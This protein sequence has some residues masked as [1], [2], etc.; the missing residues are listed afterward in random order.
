M[1]KVNP[2]RRSLLR[3]FMASSVGTGLSR[4]LGLARELA[5]ANVLG[6][7]MVMDAFVMAFTFPGMLRR[8]VADEGLTGALVP[9]I[10][11]AETEDGTEAARQLA[12]RVLMA[13]IAVGVLLSTAGILAAPWIVDWVADGFKGEKYTL[14]VQL[15]QVLFPFVIFVSLV[16]WAEGLLN[17]KDHF[18][19][20]KIAP[21]L[22]SA[23][24]VAAVLLYRNQG[25]IDVVWAVSWAVIIGGAIHLLICIPP[26]IKHWGAIRP[27]FDLSVDPRF[28]RVVGEM[29]KVAIIG[30]MA[31]VN[32]LAL[33]YLAS[34]L[35]EGSV[36]WYWNA[37]RLVDFAQGI[38]AVGVGSALLPAI[39]DAVSNND[40]DKF[41]SSFSG[42]SRLAG[43]LLIPAAAFIL[44]FPVPC[45]AVLYRH[46]A[47]SW[48]D[49]EQTAA[50][51]Q[52][53]V[54]FMLALAGIQ[55][56]KKPFFA[57]ERRDALIAVGIFGVGL[58][59]GL[60]MWLAPLMGVQGLSLALS[61]STCFQLLAYLLLL[62]R[63]VPGGL[64]LKSLFKD[65]TSMVIST[66]PAIV[67]GWL[68]I[69]QG[70]WE[71][72]PSIWNFGILGIA[73][74]VGGIAYVITAGLLGIK[75]VKSV[76]SR[77]RRQLG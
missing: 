6:A 71:S 43:A 8:F 11:K 39:S 28:R 25:P 7:G 40:G 32:T 14:T 13:L 59:V 35:A 58:T 31:Q 53:L 30:L 66:I 52:M 69:Q 38:I 36:T 49:V 10:S 60:G 20:P 56:V 21:G 48:V 15:T 22:V 3:A 74:V 2:P 65:C 44:F 4:I 51:L 5:L 64:G 70:Q 76:M 73:G 34:Q 26:L 41:R 75:E 9:A 68:I 67:L 77:I 17:H 63:M 50:A 37:T 54:P 46:G 16:S 42:A 19:I 61:L 72:G 18:F 29:G 33:R 45:V 47:Y 27:R 57:L 12:G 62:T 1:P 55:I 24:M 23:T